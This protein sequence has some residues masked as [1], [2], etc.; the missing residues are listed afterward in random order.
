VEKTAIKHSYNSQ[1]KGCHTENTYVSISKENILKKIV[2][3]FS[4]RMTL[5]SQTIKNKIFL[6]FIKTIGILF[7]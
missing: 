3:F 4:R 7:R 2:L 1:L 6:S 5:L